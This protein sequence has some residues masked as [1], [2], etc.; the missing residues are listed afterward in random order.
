MSVRSK[1]ERQLNFRHIGFAYKIPDAGRS[2]KPFDY[3]VGMPITIDGITLLRFIAIEAKKA[4]GWSLHKSKWQDHQR[5]ALDAVDR[6]CPNCA[7]VAIGFLDIPNMKL[8]HNRAPIAGRRH[9]EAYLIRWRDF[10]EI[11]GEISCGYGD[12]AEN[13]ADFILEYGKQGSRYLW[14]V[15]ANHPL[16]DIF[17]PDVVYN[18]SP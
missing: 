15:P 3:V 16:R 13:F 7:W 1:F 4:D 10:K 14:L 18:M 9:K 8:D 12:I 11:E 17:L 2:L 6:L 5:N